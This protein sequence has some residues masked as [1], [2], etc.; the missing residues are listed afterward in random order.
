MVVPGGRAVSDERDT[1]VHRN[2]KIPEEL[3]GRM[4]GRMEKAA[5]CL[6]LSVQIRSGERTPAVGFRVQG[7]GCRVQG[8]GFRV[9]GSGCRV[10]GW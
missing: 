10:E 8:A 5:G 6:P 4:D 1:P 3:L 9:Q 7:S 2:P